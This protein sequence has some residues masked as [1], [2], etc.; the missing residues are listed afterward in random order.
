MIYNDKKINLS[1]SF[2]LTHGRHG[3]TVESV[4]IQVQSVLLVAVVVL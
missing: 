3:L 1:D 4:C 2:V